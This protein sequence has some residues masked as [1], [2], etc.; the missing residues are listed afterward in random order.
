[1]LW[2]LDSKIRNKTLEYTWENIYDFRLYK[3]F[4][5]SLRLLKI[6]KLHFCSLIDIQKV[7]RQ[8]TDRKKILQNTYVI[9]PLYPEYTYIEFIQLKRQITKKKQKI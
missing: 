1:M 2:T 8:I 7:E 3:D 5:N 6:D 4:I 9:K